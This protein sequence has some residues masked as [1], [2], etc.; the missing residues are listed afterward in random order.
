MLSPHR[1]LVVTRQRVDDLADF[2]RELRV[3]RDNRNAVQEIAAL[4]A[5]R[6]ILCARIRE[7]QANDNRNTR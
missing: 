1:D 4:M 7:I 2:I 3:S 6:M 5:E